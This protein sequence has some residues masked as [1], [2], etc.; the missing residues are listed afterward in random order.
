MTK[1]RFETPFIY[2]FRQKFHSSG[3]G[4]LH[5][6]GPALNFLVSL[7]H[8]IQYAHDII[9]NS[10]SPRRASDLN[11]FN[12]ESFHALVSIILVS[13]ANFVMRFQLL[14]CSLTMA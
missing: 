8:M 13:S 5:S 1:P 9:L 12:H 7:Y 14:N 2:A 11:G 10:S 4:D 3:R 6:S